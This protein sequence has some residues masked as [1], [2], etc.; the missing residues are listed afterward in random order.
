MKKFLYVF[1]AAIAAVCFLSGC[2]SKIDYSDYVSERRSNIYLYSDDGLEIK[3]NICERETPYSLDGIKGDVSD[4]LEIFVTLPENYSEVGVSVGSINGEMNYKAV[5][6][7]YYVSAGAT[8]SGESVAV[9]LTYNGES[10]EYTALSVLYDGVITCDEA[11]ECAV[12][13]DGE[14]FNSLAEKGIF[15]AEISVRLLFDEGCYY[16]VGVCDREKKITAYLVDGEKGTVI[17][18]KQLG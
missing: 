6:N 1:L 18:T 16:Y 5:E 10:K 9:T 2:Q 17:A 11:V 7:C 13:H 15:L 14:L 8:L 3:I 12:E 4:F